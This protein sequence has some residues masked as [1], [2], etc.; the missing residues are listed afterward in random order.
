MTQRIKRQI[1]SKKD[2]HLMPSFDSVKRFKVGK[3]FQ[4]YK[5]GGELTYSSMCVWTIYIL[6]LCWSCV[7]IMCIHVLI[8]DLVLILCAFILCAY[9]LECALIEFTIL[10]DFYFIVHKDKSWQ[11]IITLYNKINRSWKWVVKIYCSSISHL[12]YSIYWCYQ[13][14]VLQYFGSL[15]KVKT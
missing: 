9:L 4:F 1:I 12:R 8:I 5:L 2:F 3:V 10:L 15:T 13:K 7:D 14:Y 6:I 11:Y